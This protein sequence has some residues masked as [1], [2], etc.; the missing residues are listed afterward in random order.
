M[1]LPQKLQFAIALYY[2]HSNSQWSIGGHASN[3]SPF[4]WTVTRTDFKWDKEADWQNICKIAKEYKISI[5]ACAGTFWFK[6]KG[7]KSTY[8]LNQSH[9]PELKKH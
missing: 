9:F 7:K 5:S 4:Q 8:E 6:F 1:K 2:I 3:G